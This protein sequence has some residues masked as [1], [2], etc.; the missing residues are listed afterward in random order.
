MKKWKVFSFGLLVITA[1]A[2]FIFST[3]QIELFG[4]TNEAALEAEFGENVEYL[5]EGM[6]VEAL[7]K[8]IAEEESVV[9]PEKMGTEPLKIA[10]RQLTRAFVE[11]TAVNPKSVSDWS[12]FMS[13][14]SDSSVDK[15]TLTQSFGSGSASAAGTVSHD[16][17]IDGGGNTITW[18]GTS[19]HSISIGSVGRPTT[20]TL[21]N[22]TY[23]GG[24]S[25]SGI[26]KGA[27][28]NW[29]VNLH[30]VSA[31]D[32]N[33][34]P[35][36]DMDGATVNM[37]GKN[38]L[39]Y[40]NTKSLISAAQFNLNDTLNYNS[41]NKR[42]IFLASS[43]DLQAS[44]NGASIT[45]DSI[46]HLFSGQNTVVTMDQTTINATNNFGGVSEGTASVNLQ[47]T[48]STVDVN[49]LD[50]ELASAPHI[51]SEISDSNIDVHD[52]VTSSFFN[53]TSRGKAAS[54][55]KIID[56]NFNINQNKSATHLFNFETQTNMSV[57]GG[58]F[59][60]KAKKI[61]FQ[62]LSGA[63]NSQMVIDKGSVWNAYSFD[64]SV[65]NTAN[66]DNFTLIAKD[67]GT[68]LNFSG[69]SNSTGDEGG[70][71]SIYGKKSDFMLSN[72]AVL[73]IDSL[74]DKD[75]TP[76]IMME[77]EGG[78]FYVSGKSEL[79]V[80]SFGDSNSRA[81]TVRFRLKGNM[82][83][84]VSEESKIDIFKH[85]STPGIRMYGSN[86]KIKVSGGSDF[87]IYNDGTGSSASDGSDLGAPQG[88]LFTHSSSVNEFIVNDEDSNISI[89]AE[90]APAIDSRSGSLLIEA[91]DGSYFV[92]KG[93]TKSKDK[94]VFAGNV[95]NI[96]FG[97][98]KYYDF[99]N[100]R[101][102]GGIVFDVAKGSSIESEISDFS[103]WQT[104]TSVTGNPT[105]SY[106][107]V[108]YHLSGA[109]FSTFVSGDNEVRDY[110]NTVGMN[111]TTRISGNNQRAVIDELR[112]PTNADKYIWGHA[113]V[114]EGKHDANRDAWTDEVKV[115][116]GIY[117]KSNS[118]IK[119][120][121]GTIVEGA[122]GTGTVSVYGDNQRA[123]IF[124][125]D[126]E[127]P[128]DLLT[129]D[130]QLKV[131]EAWRGDLAAGKAHI[132]IESDFQA[133]DRTVLDVTPPTPTKIGLD[134]VTNGDKQLEGS[135]AEVAAK[136]YTYYKG[137]SLA[138]GETVV[139]SSGN[140]TIDLPQY[141]EKT[142]EVNVYLE[143]T[144][145]KHLAAELITNEQ[146]QEV[147]DQI[148]LIKPP[149]TNN[150][151]GNI[152][153]YEDLV[154]HDTTFKGVK[155]YQVTD[156]IPS[157]PVV[158]KKVVSDTLDG[159]N[160]QI[161]QVGSELTYTITIK[162]NDTVASNKIWYD[163]ALDDTLP[164]GLAFSLEKGEVKINDQVAAADLVT[165]KAD[166]RQ[167]IVKLGDLKPQE[168]A[169]VSFKTTVTREAV[170]TVVENIAWGTGHS[171]QE[172]PFVPGPINPDSE[173]VIIKDK[174]SVV[175]PGGTV[176]GQL[177]LESAPTEVDFGTVDVIDFQKKISV[178][179]ADM[180]TPLL[181][182]DTRKSRTPWHITAE[183]VKEM[184][185]GD[186]EHIGALKYRY[187]GKDLTLDS[188]IKTVYA[189]DADT[190]DYLFNI[191][192]S[193]GKTA[194]SEGLKLVMD[195]VKVPKTTG[196]YEGIIRW[197][198]R[199]TIE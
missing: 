7:R 198:L 72:E 121:Q 156:L 112:M 193:W 39:T 32:K 4:K 97:T 139:D 83:F 92:A 79:N 81:S 144:V 75:A 13:A 21:M 90:K 27:G 122:A 170:D 41:T 123:G 103:A 183:V 87:I 128:D 5:E 18:A 153:P 63:A 197:T 108:K 142:E 48:H 42:G 68:V 44:I 95:S 62:F 53:V 104:G 15:I 40:N 176:A 3:D 140:W 148:G 141:L 61:M 190:D 117:D 158:T 120:V 195:P 118:L 126:T 46:A 98:M 135:D 50:G 12:G 184:I 138:N 77:S 84:D 175:N 17:V 33:R 162:N 150:Q 71:I 89:I 182:E 164:V 177:M 67:P 58:K 132:S 85:G 179:N 136:A 189:N 70:I 147:Y 178:N 167:L 157:P 100:T 188:S 93:Q 129:Q 165:Y 185:N 173:H 88:I 107:Q 66:S 152:N 8:K 28:N 172:T 73:N 38:D 181:V 69:H 96:H 80:K 23:T 194:N 25:S 168:T 1:F 106:V 47:M 60:L 45:T 186:D 86:N 6:T 82:V 114:P 125:I 99:T 149:V 199:D 124:K 145:G 196:S 160:N 19:G 109:N 30:D 110:F 102:A 174:G 115:V 180:A 171:P 14:L 16:V 22:F 134:K 24:N 10:E 154:Y 133:P 151:N 143:D 91:G 101:P 56:S 163:A 51:N 146:G 31:T 130:Y 34:R 35:L 65:I 36:I 119:K 49:T 64:D 52:D 11:T 37:T 105:K 127:L 29:T 116:V 59:D 137:A 76:T 111:K 57:S 94:G 166:D 54:D 131:L 78:G 2:L 20:L 26:F 43:G 161:T 55:I 169:T 187:N 159:G 192:D 113:G 74:K 191:S 9:V 155:K